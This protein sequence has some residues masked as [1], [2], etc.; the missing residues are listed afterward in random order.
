MSFSSVKVEEG[1]CGPEKRAPR[2]LCLADAISTEPCETAEVFRLALFRIESFVHDT[3]R[4]G[5]SGTALNHAFL[6][7]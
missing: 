6:G 3:G 7:L 5:T 4:T 1:T 2:S